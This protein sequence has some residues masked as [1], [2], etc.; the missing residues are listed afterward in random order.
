V[1]HPAEESVQAP[2]AVPLT[3]LVL[4][5]YESAPPAVRNRMLTRL[6]G[7]VYEAASP[8]VRTLLLEKLLQPMGVLSLVTV[9]NGIFASIRLRGDWPQFQV[10][11]EDAQTVRARDVVALAD[12][13]L[14]ASS[15]AINGLSEVIATSPVLASSAAATVL[16]MALLRRN[17]ARRATDAE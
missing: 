12:Y 16:T 11:A 8:T 3:A 4:D 1:T 5:V 7:Q 13:L 10:R 17:H 6:V 2:P 14:Q 15:E 9:A